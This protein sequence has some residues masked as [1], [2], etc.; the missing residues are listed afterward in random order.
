MTH[1][2]LSIYP[3]KLMEYGL[4]VLYLLFFVPFWAYV[5]GGRRTARAA[6]GP[7][8]VPV[9]HDVNVPAGR[10][11]APA[12]PGVVAARSRRRRPAV[13]APRAHGLCAASRRMGER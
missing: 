4:A 7:R 12:G 9:S 1:E 13:H 5:Q 10:R 2:F 11:L 3:A 6:S 8:P